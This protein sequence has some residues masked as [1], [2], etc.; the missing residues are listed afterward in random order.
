MDL[1]PLGP[2]GPMV[3]AVGLGCG[4]LGDA[5]LTEGEV[6]RLLRGAVDLGV[7]LFDSARSYGP[8]EERL[9]RHL[10]GLP[11]VRSTKGGYG[12]AGVE[13]WSPEAVRRGLD[14]ALVRLQ[15]EQLD[16]FLFHSCPLPTLRREDLLAELDRAR[17]SGKLKVAGYSGDND[18]LRWAVASGRFGAVE[19]SFSL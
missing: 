1:R 3:S 4:A 18:E 13:D 2:S 14:E 9:G 12:I 15:V 5:R 7:T 16:L 10:R 8:S 19:A 17:A 6:E 11:V